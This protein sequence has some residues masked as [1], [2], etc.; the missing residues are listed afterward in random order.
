MIRENGFNVIKDFEFADHY[1]YRNEDIEKILNYSKNLD[2]KL[3]LRKKI[4][5]RLKQ[6]CMQR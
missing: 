2:V 5:K 6:N 4:M 1:S 3:L